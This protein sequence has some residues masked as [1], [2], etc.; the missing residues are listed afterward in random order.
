MRFREKS[1]DLVIIGSDS[2]NDSVMDLEGGQAKIVHVL[3][4]KRLVRTIILIPHYI[5]YS[6]LCYDFIPS[7]RE[8]LYCIMLSHSHWFFSL[9]TNVLSYGNTRTK[10]CQRSKRKSIHDF[11]H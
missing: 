2:E 8:T 3:R 9:F 6:M 1:R 7:C 11:R 5:F 10:S 4:L